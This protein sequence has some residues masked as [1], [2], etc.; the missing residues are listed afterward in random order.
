LPDLSLARDDGKPIEY[1]GPLMSRMR[2]RIA[3]AAGEQ[4]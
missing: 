1:D 2:M 4:S 3:P